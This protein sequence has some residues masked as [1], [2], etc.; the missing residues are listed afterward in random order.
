MVFDFWVK[1]EI[2]NKLDIKEKL[3][4]FILSQK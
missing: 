4:L 3:F 2:Y 1:R